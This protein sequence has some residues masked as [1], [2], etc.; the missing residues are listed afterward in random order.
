MKVKDMS[1]AEL[2][3]RARYYRKRLQEV[4]G[5]LALYRRWHVEDSNKIGEMSIEI[6][7]LMK[8]EDNQEAKRKK[9]KPSRRRKAKDIHSRN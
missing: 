6:E 3:K 7:R 2:I 1:R 9:A 5:K 4:E 8:N